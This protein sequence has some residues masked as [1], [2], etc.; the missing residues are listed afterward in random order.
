VKEDG[1]EAAAERVMAQVCA[2]LEPIK[3]MESL[4]EFLTKIYLPK[5]IAGYLKYYQEKHGVG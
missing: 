1:F 2:E 4:Y 5:S 3:K